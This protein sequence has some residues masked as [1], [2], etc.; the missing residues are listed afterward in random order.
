MAA[1]AGTQDG[2]LGMGFK[3]TPPNQRAASGCLGGS[4]TSH[5]K[6]NISRLKSFSVYQMIGNPTQRQFSCR[7]VQSC[8]IGAANHP[9]SRMRHGRSTNAPFTVLAIS[10]NIPKRQSKPFLTHRFRF[11]SF[12]PVPRST[13][14]RV[15][16]P[17]A[18]HP[19]WGG[20]AGI[21]RRRAACCP[22]APNSGRWFPIFPSRG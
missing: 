16:A 6:D 11:P 3:E 17:G 9:A 8:K 14:V 7:I 2:V 4:A 18:V 5:F 19:R 21:W 13:C 1:K 20:G 22:A 10:K 15:P 12:P